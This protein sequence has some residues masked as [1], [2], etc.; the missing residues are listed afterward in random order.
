MKRLVLLNTSIITTD[1]EFTYKTISYDEAF[2][3]FLHYS[4]MNYTEIVSAIGHESTAEILSTLLKTK[5]EVNRFRFSQTTED[6]C[7]VFKLNGRPPE[8]KILTKDEI[9]N[10]GYTFGI[11]TRN[12]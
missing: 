11:L 6:I 5:I 3:Y 1:G 2:K 12:K 9:E 4:E 10:I 8:G 7:L